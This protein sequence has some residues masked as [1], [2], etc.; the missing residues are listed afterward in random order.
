MLTL[1]NSCLI[2][3]ITNN[4]T[5]YINLLTLGQDAA[6][7]DNVISGDFVGAVLAETKSSA[8]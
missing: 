3:P 1:M 6:D 2:I 7:A 5:F 4:V 8:Y